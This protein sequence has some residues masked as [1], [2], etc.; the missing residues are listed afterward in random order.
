MINVPELFGSAVFNDAVMKSKLPKEVYLSLKKTIETGKDLDP[1]VAD[2]VAAAMKDWA[3]EKGATHYSHWFQPLT[4]VTAEK[5]DGFLSPAGNGAVLME[6]SGRELIRGEPDASSLPSGGLRATFEARGYTAWD[7]TSPAFVKGGTLFI[8][9]VFCS[10]G[11]QTLDTKTPLLRSV[12]EVGREALRLIRLFGDGKASSVFPTVGA[13]QEYFLIDRAYFYRR[14]DLLF[15]GRTLFGAPAPKGQELDDHYLGS[16]KPRIAAFM[17]DLD[18]ELW[19]LGVLARTKHNEAAPAQHELAP[20]FTSANIAVDGNHLTMEAMRTVAEKHGL[21]CLLHEKPFAFINGSGKHVNWSLATDTGRN[22]FDPGQTPSENAQFLLFL[23][24]VITAAD[25]YQGLLRASAA[26]AGNDFR[27]GGDE[28]PPAVFSLFL[29][30][31]L[32]AILDAL[33]SGTPYRGI[34][35][36]EMEFGIHTVPSFPKDN[37]DRNRTSPFAFTGSKFEFRMPGSSQNIALPVT[38]LNTAAADVLG[39]FADALE[40]SEDPMGDAGRL[41]AEAF[42]KHKRIIF[43]GNGYSAEWEQEAVGRGLLNLRSTPDCL[44]QMLE[45]KNAALFVR[46]GVFS[47]EE[48]RSRCGISLENYRKTVAIEARTAIKLLRQDILPAINSCLG[49]LNG[50]TRYGQEEKRTL[51]S[52]S[53]RIFDGLQALEDALERAESESDPLASARL[54]HDE[55]LERMNRI[56]K[57]A[58]EAEARMPSELLPMPTY[59]ELLFR[60]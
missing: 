19:R 44:P 50:E 37:T 7:P 42:R 26:S 36:S 9:S 35:V 30:D 10:F 34:P 27:L 24:A 14:K 53:D 29:G 60:V 48:L 59:S 11:G 55:V 28:A 54:F 32:T 40:G 2:V 33:E 43:N 18:E 56:R 21:V 51:I 31:E 23:A 20:V 15:T 41:I 47:E 8:P 58:D 46:R 17:K 22:L 1:G 38:V 45:E 6:F 25:E 4:G 52:L 49:T 12:K 39:R 16:I 57:D 5:H 13:E 3:L